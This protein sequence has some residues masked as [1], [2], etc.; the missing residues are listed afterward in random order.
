MSKKSYSKLIIILVSQ[1][2]L[3]FLCLFAAATSSG[4]RQEPTITAQP[5]LTSLARSETP[6]TSQTNIPATPTYTP[7]PTAINALTPTISPTAIPTQ[8][9]V[10]PF[11]L[12]TKIPTKTLAPIIIDSG[13]YYPSSNY[14]YQTDDSAF[15][16]PS[17]ICKDGT[18]SYSAHRRGTCSHHGGV[19]E[20]L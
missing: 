9:A 11:I 8:T 18:L 13:D 2:F 6:I 3:I 19:A 5:S 12:P 17:A 15:G 7:T 14:D 1:V 10:T 20:W 4:A 16:V